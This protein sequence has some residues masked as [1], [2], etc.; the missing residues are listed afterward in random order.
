MTDGNLLQS[1][2]RLSMRT[3]LISSD[4]MIL[5][6]IERARPDVFAPLCA[7]ASLKDLAGRPDPSSYRLVLIDG[8]AP[9]WA[10]ELVACLSGKVD[11]PSVVVLTRSNTADERVDAL[12]R[13]ADDAIWRHV[14]PTE[15]WAR[16]YALG[17]WTTRMKL[18][19]ASEA[20][21]RAGALT[22]YPASR[23]ITYD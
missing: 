16:L 8:R 14:D 17:R 7:V 6:R 11:K 10:K 19:A 5:E 12:T 18:S 20:R 9:T 3:V 1:G 21:V 15:L 2:L 22:Y 4:P 13:S 23:V